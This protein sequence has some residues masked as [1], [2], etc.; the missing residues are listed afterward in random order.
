MIAKGSR[1]MTCRRLVAATVLQTDKNSASTSPGSAR[2]PHSSDSMQASWPRC[3][4]S[5]RR[6]GCATAVAGTRMAVPSLVLFAQATPKPLPTNDRM[7]RTSTS[8]SQ[9]QTYMSPEPRI[10]SNRAVNATCKPG[11]DATPRLPTN[12]VLE[13]SASWG[14]ATSVKNGNIQFPKLNFCITYVPTS[15]VPTSVVQ[16]TA[17]ALFV[18]EHVAQ[19]P[20]ATS[21]PSP[22][23]NHSGVPMPLQPKLGDRATKPESCPVQPQTLQFS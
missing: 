20:P 9:H 22:G 2:L 21:P 11:C 16:E 23:R 1:W 8:L 15:C 10:H 19:E 13:E 5:G 4:C 18:P 14:R 12:P 17:C 6:G 3:G 7:L